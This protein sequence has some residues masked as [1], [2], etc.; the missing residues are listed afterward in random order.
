VGTKRER[1]ARSTQESGVN[2]SQAAA[3]YASG[4]G[5]MA[6]DGLDQAILYHLEHHLERHLERR[7]RATHYEVGKAVFLSASAASRRI[8]ALE[9]AGV[10]RGYRAQIDDRLPGVTRLETSF[11][12]RDVL[13]GKP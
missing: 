3:E 13:E 4:P 10:I 6:L 11:A 5:G 9:A 2:R 7:G 1:N 8:Q 12:P